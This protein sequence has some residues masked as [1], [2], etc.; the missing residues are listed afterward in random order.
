MPKKLVVTAF[1]ILFLI[2]SLIPA[3]PIVLNGAMIPELLGA[4]VASIRVVNSRGVA[5][6][7]QIDEVTKGGEYVCPQGEAP[8]ADSANGIFDKQDE[9]V[10]LLEDTDTGNL[11][12][13]TKNRISPK[14]KQSLI[15]IRSGSEIHTASIVED[16]LLPKSF[17]NYLQYDH[18][19]QFLRTPFYYA[20]FGKDRFH[21]TRAG[22]MDFATDKFIDLT[23]ELRVEIKFK[24]LWGLLPIHYTEENIICKVR[25]YKAGPVRII[26]RGDFYLELGFG[27]KGSQAIVYQLCYPQLV[28]VPVRA[29]LPLS[30]N[31][32]FG[33]AYIEMTPVIRKNTPGFRFVP[34]GPCRG[35]AG[36]LSGKGS[37][38][39]LIKIVPKKGYLV[40]DGVKGFEWITAVA[41]DDK[42][43]AGSGYIMRK[44]SSRKNG[45]AE[46]GFR[47]TVNDLP[48]GSYDIVNW[49]FFS[50]HSVAT[51][52]QGLKTILNPAKIIT[53]SSTFP[54]LLA[55]S[56]AKK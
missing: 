43:L 4:K 46:C 3:E 11:S 51:E 23:N 32:F 21:F 47:L 54:N 24:A 25:R 44:P 33:E 36:E 28:K 35:Y 30:F 42:L 7:F 37:I 38:D 31:L 9:I 27:I 19:Q 53:S 39:T 22:C 29:Y 2:I 40:T 5:I 45:A 14:R 49:V 6:P 26:R 56:P 1:F 13:E 52:G 10:F 41:V 20:Q 8:N 15:K 12:I 50:R 48:K 55:A 18:A 34:G 17:K 16:G